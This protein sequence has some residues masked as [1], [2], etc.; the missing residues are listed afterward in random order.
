MGN[1]R[2]KGLNLLILAINFLF[3]N[4]VMAFP[5]V[6]GVKDDVVYFKGLNPSSNYEAVQPKFVAERKVTADD[7]GIISLNRT[8]RY[9]IFAR[10]NYNDVYL[11]EIDYWYWWTNYNNSSDYPM[12]KCSKSGENFIVIGNIWESIDGTGNMSMTVHEDKVKIYHPQLIRPNQRVTVQWFGEWDGTNYSGTNKINKIKADA[13]GLAKLSIKDFKARATA[14][15]P[16]QFNFSLQ[17][18][19]NNI[20]SFDPVTTEIS[21]VPFCKNG[22]LF[23]PR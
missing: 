14:W 23:E 11:K 1:L 16:N 20:L 12:L 6:I 17:Q 22:V 15:I 3:P 2:D 9:P 18:N 7:C 10:G 13:C 5:E 4:I 21:T 8:D 19:N